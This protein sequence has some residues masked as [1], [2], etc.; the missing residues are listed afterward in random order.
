MAKEDFPLRWTQ[1]TEGLKEFTAGMKLSHSNSFMLYLPFFL[2]QSVSPFT[3]SPV[4]S[5]PLCLYHSVSVSFSLT[6]QLPLPGFLIPLLP[7]KIFLFLSVTSVPLLA[8]SIL[9]SISL[10]SPLSGFAFFLSFSHLIS[11]FFFLSDKIY[12]CSPTLIHTCTRTHALMHTSPSLFLS[13]LSGSLP[14]RQFWPVA[15][16]PRGN[17]AE[18]R[19]KKSNA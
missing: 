7:S 3:L 9:V 6:S 5:L 10:C 17:T 13:I 4:L 12:V 11:L 16:P 15:C 8:L 19:E 2:F 1:L 18:R 14:G